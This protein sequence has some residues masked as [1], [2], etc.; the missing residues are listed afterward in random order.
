[1]DKMQFTVVDAQDCNKALPPHIIVKVQPEGQGIK[2]LCIRDG[3]ALSACLQVQGD[4]FKVVGFNGAGNA[5][6][7]NIA[8]VPASWK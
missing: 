4:Q 8:D 3:D 5:G 6:L 1:M 2:T 7:T